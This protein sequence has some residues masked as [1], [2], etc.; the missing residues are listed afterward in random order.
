MHDDI[1]SILDLWDRYIAPLG[2]KPLNQFR[3]LTQT[4]LNHFAT[5]FV[6]PNLFRDFGAPATWSYL[7]VADRQEVEGRNHEDA[8]LLWQAG[9]QDFLAAQ[10][11]LTYFTNSLLLAQR[12]IGP[13]GKVRWT[14][15][16]TR[17]WGGLPH[18]Y[19]VE[20]DVPDLGF[21]REQLGWCRSSGKKPMDA[22]MGRVFQHFSQYVDFL[23][24]TA[25]WSGN[26]SLHIHVLFDSW[27][28][29]EKFHLDRR[30]MRAGF[31]EHWYDVERV[32]RDLLEVSERVGDREV[33]ADPI[34]RF[35]ETFRRLPGG[36]R[37]LAKPNILGMPAG[38][39]VPQLALW[40][41]LR[42]R[43]GHGSDTL[44]FRPGPFRE[45]TE[46]RR[47]RMTRGIGEAASAGPL[48]EDQRAYCET[49]LRQWFEARCDWPRLA[50]LEYDGRRWVAKF[51]NSSADENPSSIMREDYDRVLLSGR[52]AH[53]LKPP[54][55]L[56]RP[57]GN[58]MQLWLKQHRSGGGAGVPVVLAEPQEVECPPEKWLQR[59]DLSEVEWE[60]Q[61]K[62]VNREPVPDLTRRAVQ[63]AIL[64]NPFTWLKGP[65]GGGKTRGLFQVYHRVM[66]A[67]SVQL[68]MFSFNTYDLARQKVQEFNAE[69]GRRGFHAVVVEGW[70]RVYGRVCQGLG[71]R[72]L[73]RADA[74]AHGYESMFEFIQ[75]NHP[76]VI[77]GLRD[78]HAAVWGEV[79]GKKPVLMTQHSV[80]QNWT[81]NSMTRK[82]W[83]R[84]FWK[85]KDDRNRNLKAEMGLGL[86]VYDEVS[87][88]CLLE[89]HRTQ[90]V[91]WV[92]AM[93]DANPRWKADDADVI[94][95]FEIFSAWKDCGFPVFDGDEIRQE[96]SEVQ[97][98]ADAGRGD[99]THVTVED[100]G[101]YAS[102]RDPEHD[103]YRK[104]IGNTWVV[105]PT[106]WWNS[107][108]HRVVVLTTEALPTLIASR[109][110]DGH[111]L[112]A[113]DKAP[114]AITELETPEIERDEFL[115][116]LTD[117]CTARRIGDVIRRFRDKNGPG[118]VV[119]SNSAAHVPNV[120]T[121]AAAKGSND[122]RGKN[123]VQTALHM[124][125]EVYERHEVMNGWTST[126][127]CVRLA[128]VDEINQ[129]CG[130]NLGFRRSGD[131]RHV[132][133]ISPGL[134]L[135]L[136]TVLIHLCRYRERLRLDGREYKFVMAKRINTDSEVIDIARH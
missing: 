12:E 5:K 49:R 16:S 32:V 10:W 24:L 100:R 41:C 46:A 29:V 61:D 136:D 120:I 89:M 125:P 35:P 77:S 34:L 59:R 64:R 25:C 42:D 101:E 74:F 117:G 86:A 27:P 60:F 106:G 38:T 65:E 103:I 15:P 62:A 115:V 47:V 57:L 72:A 3:R 31:A 113:E 88:A 73:T 14:P 81:S 129:T 109:L 70:E 126:N 102:D 97:R 33:R 52:D 128:H 26:K 99:W 85:A 112:G 104:R 116:E 39:R 23:G 54:P 58:M 4:P 131:P 20:F 121:H 94:E 18:A 2:P 30:G 118:W 123:I 91:G 44:F 6:W 75:N 135:K 90:A 66:P 80:M 37:V 43:R 9:V 11:S 76:E 68:G 56:D 48:A 130:R 45:T 119:V 28:V 1:D 133:L 82:F 8:R 108:A 7:G 79:G 87:A 51:F 53:R 21:F 83:H 69:Q 19:T 107:L 114:W 124:N 95:R 13:D 67:L 105:R 127:T 78:W 22:P 71:V 36:S 93:L 55:R 84:D 17:V 63:Q 92:E 40:E 50:G 132:L 98:I 122:F 111:A 96:F 134:W 110:P